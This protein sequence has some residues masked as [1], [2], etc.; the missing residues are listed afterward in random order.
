V[1]RAERVEMY[2]GYE[3]RGDYGSAA[4][5]EY[6]TEGY[7][8]CGECGE[9]HDSEEDACDCCRWWCEPCDEIADYGEPCP[10]CGA[11]REE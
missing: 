8:K 5:Y 6:V 2:S 1:T 7:W 4:A 11:K 10:T 3:Y 9:R